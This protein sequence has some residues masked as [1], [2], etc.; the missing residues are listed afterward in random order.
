[1]STQSKAE[2]ELNSPLRSLV[3]S[4]RFGLFIT[5]VILINAATLGL[6]TWPPAVQQAGGLLMW[7]DHIA[8]WIFTV[9]LALKLWVY[10]QRFFTSG[11]NVFDFV[12][13][14][15]SWLPASGP[16]SVMRA[17]R[18]LRTLRLL[19]VVPQMRTVIGALFHALPGMGS[20]IAVLMLLFYVSAVMATKLFGEQFPDW[21]GGIGESMYSLFQIMTLE[22]WS[23]GIVRPIM[24]VYPLAW[25]FFVPFV[26]ITSFAVLNLFI[27]LIVNSMQSVHQETMEEAEHTAHDEREALLHEVIAL[28]SE[29]RG[30][31]KLIKVQRDDMP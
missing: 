26:I 21:F 29:V 6:E 20:I 30:L 17:L 10:R 23:M 22:S 5:V 7:I 11:W 14:A 1:M 2:S 24:D 18:V 31:T 27:A 15:A 9:E 19:S 4:R 25:L 16:L 12:I 3:E 8:L 28:R 13:V